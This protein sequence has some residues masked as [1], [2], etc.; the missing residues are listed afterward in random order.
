MDNWQEAGRA[1]GHRAVDF[2]YLFEPAATPVYRSVLERVG[3]GEGTALLDDACGAGGASRIAAERGAV[4]SAIDASERLLDIARARA[5]LADIRRGDFQHLPWPDASF[6]VVTGFMAFVPWTPGAL[7]EACRVVRPGGRVAWTFLDRPWETDWLGYLLA[8]GEYGPPGAGHPPEVSLRFLEDDGAEAFTREAGL[9]PVE[10]G[11]VDFTVEFAD[12]EIAWR[13]MAAT[14]P[15]WAAIDY[16]GE[17]RFRE[18]V[19]ELVREH[20]VA[21]A[22]IRMRHRIGY[23]IARRA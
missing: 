1:W 17:E 23:L 6:D 18:A 4:V 14:G 5:P 19:L 2:A 8:L 9:Q 3:V 20:Q 11:A 22:G 21:G 12:E 13:A 10:R 7:A 15:A 16:S